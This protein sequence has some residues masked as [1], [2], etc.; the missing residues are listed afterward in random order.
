LAATS[1]QTSKI[2]IPR[3]PATVATS[4]LSDIL[5]IPGGQEKCSLLA[6]DLTVSHLINFQLPSQ[7]KSA[8]FANAN[9]NWHFV[10]ARGIER[11]NT[12]VRA[13]RTKNGFFSRAFFAFF[14]TGFAP[15]KI[16]SVTRDR[17]ENFRKFWA[18]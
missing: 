10:R 3:I 7:R 14:V 18:L 11:G 2:R 17:F 9:Q 1:K 15:S 13:T 12:P 6:R 8:T 4:R 5:R 16:P